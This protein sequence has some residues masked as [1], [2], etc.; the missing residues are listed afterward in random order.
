MVRHDFG[1]PQLRVARWAHARSPP[2]SR[3]SPRTRTSTPATSSSV[4]VHCLVTMDHKEAE[5][6]RHASAS[7]GDSG[8]EGELLLLAE[9][10]AQLESALACLVRALEAEEAGSAARPAASPSPAALVEA[11]GAYREALLT[12][13]TAQHQSLPLCAA[14]AQDDAQACSRLAVIE[15]LLCGLRESFASR[16][17]V[18]D[19]AADGERGRARACSSHTRRGPAAVSAAGA[20]AERLCVAAVA[21]ARWARPP[22]RRRRAAAALAGEQQPARGG[23]AL[24]AAATAARSGVQVRSLT[25]AAPRGAGRQPGLVGLRSSGQQHPHAAGGRAAPPGRVAGQPSRRR[26]PAAAGAGAAAGHTAARAGPRSITTG[27]GAGAPAA[28]VPDV[29]QRE[30]RRRGRP[31]VRR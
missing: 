26:W 23:S 8:D 22:S 12:L 10:H 15:E 3:P 19:L 9:L 29:A 21:S 25:A 20:G 4:A 2:A 6:H 7:V 17:Q 5:H 30:P 24:A 11:L 16:A 14:A 18:R 28:A 1:G 13:A 31:R 27:R